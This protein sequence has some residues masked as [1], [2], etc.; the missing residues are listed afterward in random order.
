[1]HKRV[2]LV[3]ESDAT[4]GVAETVL[5]QNGYE[6]IS[7]ST[8]EKALEVIEFTNPDL[9]IVGSEIKSGGNQYL[10]E[11]F[12]KEAKTGSIPKLLF[13]SQNEISFNYPKEIEIELPLDPKRFIETVTQI[14]SQQEIVKS[15][16][17]NPL[18][19]ADLEDEFLDAALGL[20]QIEVT[21]SEVMDKTVLPNLEKR[22][23]AD[24]MVGMSHILKE[25]TDS[26]DSGK[27][28]SVVI[29]AD[30]TDIVQRTKQS[31]IDPK[32]ITGKLDILSD[33][34]GLVESNSLDDADAD[35]D[36]DYQWFINSMQSDNNDPAPDNSN[37]SN[38]SVK[39]NIAANS[40][41]IDPVTPA[42]DS[43]IKQPQI[44]QKHEGVEHF[45]EEFKKEVE[46][47]HTESPESIL[48][49][50]TDTTPSVE[51]KS[52]AWEEKLE[53]MTADQLGIFTRQ[54]TKDL[55]EKIAEKITA[56]IDTEKLLVLLKREI[57]AQS[58]KNNF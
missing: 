29:T 27:V 2:L 38:K 55:A 17:N 51:D 39:L 54:F 50:E 35:A 10:Y 32:N 34:Y 49:K 37:I 47:I 58:Q 41:I 24:K 42:P 18:S 45:I 33:Q 12:C 1:M 44:D 7:V 56:K 3:E 30:S 36:H 8:S 31:N 6:V 52:M 9:I 46:K 22:Q 40:E 4:R 57:I 15:A 26:S 16:K 53:Q 28:E 43:P 23:S 25:D 20:D 19:E 21:D 11:R 14:T 13:S 5:R 48:L